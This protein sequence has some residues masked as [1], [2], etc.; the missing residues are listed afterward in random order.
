MNPTDPIAKAQLK[1]ARRAVAQ[2]N[3]AL[4]GGDWWVAHKSAMMAYWKRK[5]DKARGVK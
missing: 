1:R 3:T 4:A 2:F 5:A